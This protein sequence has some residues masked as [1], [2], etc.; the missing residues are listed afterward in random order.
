MHFYIGVDSGGTKTQT[1]LVNADGQLLASHLAGST[2][3]FNIPEKRAKKI[4]SSSIE[5][6]LGQA[7]IEKKQVDYS[8]FAMS[9]YG[10]IPNRMNLIENISAFASPSAHVVVNDVR[11]ALEGA[12]PLAPGIVVLIGTGAMI[13][14][15]DQQDRISRVDGWGENVGDL[16]SG[17]YIG[18]RGL[19]EAFKAYD[20]RNPVASPL[21]EA[22]LLHMTKNGDLFSIIERCKGSNSRGFIAGFCQYVTQLADAGDEIASMIIDESLSEIRLSIQTII[23][24]ISSKKI[25]CSYAG[26]LFKCRSFKKGLDKIVE[27]ESRLVLKP[28]SVN[29]SLGAVILAV[30]KHQPEKYET[31]IKN[32]IKNH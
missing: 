24:K 5:K 31:I 20:D 9:T 1:V 15:K 18:R 10:D 17:Y 12:H 2:D 26:S 8:C 25:R 13:M 4:L 23:K 29:P 21:L 6:V 7:G 11:A 32:I 28:A 27:K 22:A 30:K 14:G 3:I 16:G 19:Q